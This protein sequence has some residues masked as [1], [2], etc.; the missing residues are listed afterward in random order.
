M[1]NGTSVFIRHAVGLEKRGTEWKNSHFKAEEKEKK[2]ALIKALGRCSSKPLFNEVQLSLVGNI[3]SV[4]LDCR[5]N[6]RYPIH[7]HIWRSSN[8]NFPFHATFIPNAK[9]NRRCLTHVKTPVTFI[10]GTPAPRFYFQH[11][12]RSLFPERKNCFDKQVNCRFVC[13][14]HHGIWILFPRWQISS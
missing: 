6:C 7:F 1:W 2:Q 14:S 9:T 11:G 4:R 8:T 12:R 13:C 5:R 10:S 3:R